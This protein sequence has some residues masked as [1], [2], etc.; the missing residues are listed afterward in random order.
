[1][2]PSLKTRKP[3]D[4]LR[5]SDLKTFP[6]WEFASD[7]KGEEGQDETWVRPRRARQVPANAYSLSV[8]AV[9]VAADGA[10]YEGIVSVNT[11]EGF[12]AVHAAVLTE[13]N[14]VFIP[15]PGMDGAAKTARSAAKELGVRARDLFPLAYRLAV[16]LE[17]ESSLREGVYRYARGDA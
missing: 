14:Y 11:A 5:P 12:E 3:L 17:G 2:R 16:P 7:E 15:W 4:Q 10:E 13:D 1:M 8:A 9:L 6:V